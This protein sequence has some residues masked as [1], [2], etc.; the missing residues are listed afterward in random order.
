MAGFNDSYLHE[1]VQTARYHIESRFHCMEEN[2]VMYFSSSGFSSIEQLYWEKKMQLRSLQFFFVPWQWLLACYCRWLMQS[3]PE[4]NNKWTFAPASCNKCSSVWTCVRWSCEWVCLC[5]S[6]PLCCVCN[7]ATT[8]HFSFS[9]SEVWKPSLPP[10]RI[11]ASYWL[12]LNSPKPA[13]CY[14]N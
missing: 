2:S 11:I 4:H 1:K 6:I 9:Q 5:L 7:K 8:C 10:G 14:L 3:R 13:S 12:P